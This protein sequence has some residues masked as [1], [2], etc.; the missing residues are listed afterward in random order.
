MFSVVGKGIGTSWSLA[1]RGLGATT[2]T[3]SRATE[4]EHGHRRDGIALGLIAISGIVAA[5]VWLSA[6]GPVGRWID[7]GVSAVVGDAARL[8]PIVC[9]LIAVILMLANIAN[10]SGGSSTMGYALAAVGPVFPLLAPVIGW[11]GVFLTGS[12]VNNNTLFA[13]LQVAT[14]ERL[15]HDVA[16]GREDATVEEARRQE[17][18]DEQ[19]APGIG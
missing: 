15:G 17:V 7:T 5:S 16:A 18:R 10:H 14:A 1:A 11:I 13:P 4:I 2:R 9:G 3:V 12:V 6:G 8:I 19:H